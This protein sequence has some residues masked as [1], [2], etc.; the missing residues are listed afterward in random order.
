M[1][2]CR[3]KLPSRLAGEWPEAQTPAVSESEEKRFAERF[4]SADWSYRKDM[5]SLDDPAHVIMDK[6][7]KNKEYIRRFSLP[8]WTSRVLSHVEG[9]SL[10]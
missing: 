7:M 1:G 10:T 5:D 6:H 3:W 8:P 2:Y 9:R 4:A